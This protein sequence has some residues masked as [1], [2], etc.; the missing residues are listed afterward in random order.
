MRTPRYPKAEVPGWADEGRH[1]KEECRYLPYS[2]AEGRYIKGRVER[3]PTLRQRC[4]A[5]LMRRGTR[6]SLSTILLAS[7]Y[8]PYMPTTNRFFWVYACKCV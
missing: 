2:K 3:T 6:K 1:K 7:R 4:Q 8:P 5:G